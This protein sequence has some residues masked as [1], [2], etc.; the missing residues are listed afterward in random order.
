MLLYHQL[1]GYRFT[2]SVC[3]YVFSMFG[4]NLFLF[5][6]KYKEDIVSDSVG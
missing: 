4:K 6:I 1:I 5:N 2:P 3:A